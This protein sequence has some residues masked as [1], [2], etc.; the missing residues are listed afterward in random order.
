MP[1]HQDA[2]RYELS[3]AERRDLIKLINEGDEA[4][5]ERDK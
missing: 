2:E 5:P 3:D 4:P 1:R